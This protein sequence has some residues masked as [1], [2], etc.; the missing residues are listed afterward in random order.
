MWASRADDV[1]P[2]SGVEKYVKKL[3]RCVQ[4]HR[5]TTSSHMSRRLDSSD[6]LYHRGSRIKS[7]IPRGSVLFHVDERHDHYSSDRS[8]HQKFEMV[9][10]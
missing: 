4:Q 1:I 6:K 7:L 5:N 8:L 9:S 3:R 10:C 2:F